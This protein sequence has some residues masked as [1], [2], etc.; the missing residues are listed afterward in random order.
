MKK[1]NTIEDE[2]DAIR[3]NIYERTKNMS[4][5]EFLEYFNKLGD[6][7]AEKYGFKIVDSLDSPKVL[8]SPT[9]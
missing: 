6:E 1:S 3:L 5:K 9:K 8:K 4:R 2:L 7:M